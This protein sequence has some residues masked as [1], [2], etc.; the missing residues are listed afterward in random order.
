MLARP[1]PGLREMRVFSKRHG[2]AFAPLFFAASSDFSLSARGQ[3]CPRR[4]SFAPIFNRTIAALGVVENREARH[5][6]CID[7]FF[8]GPPPAV[9]LLFFPCV[10]FPKRQTGVL[11]RDFSNEKRVPTLAPLEVSRVGRR[12]AGA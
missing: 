12:S 10:F 3:G 7:F 1:E 9:A 11:A 8:K 4:D 5:T 6:R 2:R